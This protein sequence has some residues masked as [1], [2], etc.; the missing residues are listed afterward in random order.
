MTQGPGSRARRPGVGGNAT[1][2]HKR[3]VDVGCTTL[4]HNILFILTFPS[5]VCKE[6]CV[7][8]RMDELF[9]HLGDDTEKEMEINNIT[10]RQRESYYHQD[11]TFERRGNILKKMKDNCHSK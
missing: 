5:S 6:V 10:I 2:T 9:T 3:Y 8:R 11:N 7:I 1:A 4:H